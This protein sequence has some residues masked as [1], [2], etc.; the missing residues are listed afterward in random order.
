V[1]CINKKS[2]KTEMNEAIRDKE[3]RLV[4]EEGEQLGIMSAKDALLL[5]IEKKLDLVK[6]APQAVPPVC[7][8]MDYGKH[9]Y[10]SQKREKEAKKKQKQSVLKEVR[11]SLNIEKHDMETKV[12]HAIKFLQE[13]DKVKVA[14][15]FRGRELGNTNLGREVI[16]K[17]VEL[18]SEEGV[19]EKTPLLE[20]K[21]MVAIISPK[22]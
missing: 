14:L 21:S 20:G 2:D 8:I 19:L 18:V 6:I 4:G 17:F 12:N 15:R 3:V 11:L 22:N 7:K 16:N 1:F 13:G 5:A 10:E 9:R